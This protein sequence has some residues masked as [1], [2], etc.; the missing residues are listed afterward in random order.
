MDQT[1]KVHYTVGSVMEPNRNPIVAHDLHFSYIVRMVADDARNYGNCAM[2]D[3]RALSSHSLQFSIS[4][5]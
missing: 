1:S 4:S 3:G 2:V 5:A